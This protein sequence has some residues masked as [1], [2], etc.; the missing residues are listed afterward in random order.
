MRQLSAQILLF[1][2][3]VLALLAPVGTTQAQDGFQVRGYVHY[4]A[5][6]FDESLPGASGAGSELRR[7]RPIFEYRGKGWSARFMPDLQRAT[8]QALDAY[9]D[10]TPEGPWDLRIGRFKTPLSLN[11]LQ[12]SGALVPMENSVVAGMTPNRDNGVLLGW[13]VA[14]GWRIEAGAFDGAADDE[15]KGALDSGVE[16]V[17]RLAHER[18]VGEGTLRLGVGASGGDRTGAVGEARLARYRTPGRATWF[19]YVGSAFADGATGRA[20][21]SIDYQHGPWF[22]QAEAIES[23]ERVRAAGQAAAVAHRAWEVVGSRVLTGEKRTDRGVTPGNWKIPGLDVPVAVELGAHIGHAQ[24]D[25]DAFRLGLA[26][27]AT[28]GRAFD[29]AGVALSFWF[30]KQWRLTVDYEHGTVHGAGT[31]PDHREQAL[32]AR[33]AI[34]F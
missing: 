5:R 27:A 21:A 20:I 24:V 18:K 31:T 3:V 30:P 4:D 33:L 28:S 22:A 1:P 12:S 13:D 19:R 6:R 11:R 10:F 29:S 9:I 23:R 15:V 25:Q 8:N 2:S 32:M 34:A 7:V 26:S 17:A 14:S 16:W